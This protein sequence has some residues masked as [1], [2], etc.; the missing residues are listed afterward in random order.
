MNTA[1]MSDHI[2]R[3]KDDHK[4]FNVDSL[5]INLDSD[6]YLSFKKWF[7]EAC[8]KKNQSLMPFV[9]LPLT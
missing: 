6:P 3:L 5:D 9:F 1:A 2:Q 7:D 8:D 4:D